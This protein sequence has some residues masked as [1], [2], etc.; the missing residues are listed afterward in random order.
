MTVGN[1]PGDWHIQLPWLDFRFTL[2]G[3]ATP[4]PSGN[5]GVSEDE[6]VHISAKYGQLIAHLIKKKVIK[7]GQA[8]GWLSED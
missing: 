8:N 7:I 2:P 4:A 5:M 1:T 6:E 3:R